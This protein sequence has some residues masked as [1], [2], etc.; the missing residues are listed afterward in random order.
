MAPLRPQPPLVKRWAST[1]LSIAPGGVRPS[2]GP[3]SLSTSGSRPTVGKCDD[4]KPGGA[5]AD[6]LTDDVARCD[7][8]VS[9]QREGGGGARARRGNEAWGVGTKLGVW[10]QTEGRGMSGAR[11][12]NCGWKPQP[13]WPREIRVRGN[14]GAAADRAAPVRRRKEVGAARGSGR[15]QTRRCRSRGNA[16]TFLAGQTGRRNF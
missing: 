1:T 13:G 12:E 9:K 5:P 11:V 7:A 3:F 4:R 2:R 15:V 8:A 16:A 6:F 10:R 14:R